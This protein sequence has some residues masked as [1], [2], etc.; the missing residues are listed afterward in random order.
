MCGREKRGERKAMEE[1]GGR[2]EILGQLGQ[3]GTGQAG[4]FDGQN[5]TNGPEGL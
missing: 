3:V 2:D 1:A 4:R 5:L